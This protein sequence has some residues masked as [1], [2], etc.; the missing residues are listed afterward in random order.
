ML[1]DH[2]DVDGAMVPPDSSEETI[3]LITCVCR[4]HV[5]AVVLVELRVVY[6]A[7][8]IKPRCVDVPAGT[9]CTPSGQSTSQGRKPSE[10]VPGRPAGQRTLSYF[11]VGAHGRPSLEPRASGHAD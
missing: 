7:L 1:E 11:A 3:R 8:A 2:R 9:A 6:D 5:S 10:H 4:A